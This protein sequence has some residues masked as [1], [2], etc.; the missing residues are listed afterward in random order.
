M[1]HMPWYR[2]RVACGDVRCA[3][4]CVRGA[5]HLALLKRID[6]DKQAS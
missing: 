5:C 4:L 2:V 3:P 1:G 6:T